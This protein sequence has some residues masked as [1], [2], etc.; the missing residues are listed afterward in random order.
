MSIDQGLKRIYHVI[1]SN[2]C[3]DSYFRANPYQKIIQIL[4]RTL[5]PF[6]E[7]DRVYAYGFGDSAS[8]DV[9][10]FN[11]M[12]SDADDDKEKPCH[13]F[14]QGAH[15]HTIYYYD[16]KASNNSSFYIIS[17]RKILNATLFFIFYSFTT[18]QHGC[19]SCQFKWAN[20]FC[21]NHPESNRT[22]DKLKKPGNYLLI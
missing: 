11:L 1:Y 13:D 4:G 14:R 21:A 6:T 5:E 10:V 18:I 19:A 16:M 9:S 8:Q 17:A 15:K 20:Q 2:I 7:T 12:Q 3:I 22:C